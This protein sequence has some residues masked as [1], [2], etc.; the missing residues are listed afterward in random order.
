M[1]AFRYKL[2]IIPR[3]FIGHAPVTV[4]PEDALQEGIEP[5]SAALQPS[6]ATKDRLRTLLPKNTSWGKTEEY[7]SNGEW[8]S[9]LCI[10]H[11]DGGWISNIDFG[12]SAFCGD[13]QLMQEFVSIVRAEDCLLVEGRTGLVMPPSDELVESEF[14][15]SNAARFLVDPESALRQ[16]SAGVREPRISEEKT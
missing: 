9:K 4:I 6:Q 12:Y 1:A 15:K 13:W 2:L 14:K 11:D 3:S 5:W 10:W 16:A 7:V 8:T